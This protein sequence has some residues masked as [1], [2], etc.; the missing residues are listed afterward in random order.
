[1]GFVDIGVEQGDGCS[2][3]LVQV[4][5]LS[6]RFPPFCGIKKAHGFVLIHALGGLYSVLREFKSLGLGKIGS[7][8]LSFYL[9]V[10]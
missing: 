5:L 4:G 3:D 10:F 7:F 1:W 9:C 6:H 2:F 8:H